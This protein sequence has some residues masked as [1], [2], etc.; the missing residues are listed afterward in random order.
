MNQTINEAIRALLI[1]QG[2]LQVLEQQTID[3]HDRDTIRDIMDELDGMV[4]RAEELGL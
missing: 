2:I 1:A 4:H 3:Q